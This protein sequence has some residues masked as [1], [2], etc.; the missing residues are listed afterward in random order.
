MVT[1]ASTEH[2]YWLA[3]AFVAWN[4][5]AT[6]AIAS[7]WKPGFID[8]ARCTVTIVSNHQPLCDAV[9]SGTS[10]VVFQSIAELLSSNVLRVQKRAVKI[11]YG[12]YCTDYETTCSQL[13]IRSLENH[14][15]DLSKSFFRK[16]V[17]DPKS[18]LHYLLPEPRG[19]FV[20]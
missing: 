17:M 9:T 7:E 15:S 14:R 8:T 6:Q 5:H 2:S 13:N 3:L 10:D 19:D 20:D 4:F 18:C 16:S 12:H 11:I 1:T